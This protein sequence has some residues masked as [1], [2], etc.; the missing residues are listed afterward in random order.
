MYLSNADMEL[1]R[2][3]GW[4]KNLPSDMAES[5]RTQA[6][7][8]AGIALLDKLGLL[9]VTGNGRSV[10]LRERGWRLLRYLGYDYH[11]D[12]RYRS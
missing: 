12:N 4:C 9:M 10:R 7:D 1:L 2:L 6:F 3:A 11:K 8:P 5:F